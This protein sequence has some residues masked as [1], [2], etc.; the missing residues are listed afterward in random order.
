MHCIS[1]GIE[2]FKEEYGN[3]KDADIC[4]YCFADKLND[5]RSREEYN[6]P[7]PE[8]Q[9][10][11]DQI[12]ATCEIKLESSGANAEAEAYEQIIRIIKS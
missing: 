2:T 9:W 1:C 7:K 6:A 10:L 12:Q 4:G 11:I 8:P 5:I 3:P